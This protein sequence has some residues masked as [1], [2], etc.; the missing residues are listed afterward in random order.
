MKKKRKERK[1]RKSERRREE[2][3]LGSINR[4]ILY[5][6]GFCHTVNRYIKDLQ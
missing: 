1:K 6:I 2:G 4:K 5:T 3:D